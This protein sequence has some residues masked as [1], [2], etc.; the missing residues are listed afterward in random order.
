[1]KTLPILALTLLLS[2]LPGISQVVCKETEAHLV[3]TC[4]GR[5]VLTYHKTASVP[6]EVD[7][8]YARSGFIHPLSTPSGRVL[9]DDYPVPHH[10]HQHGVFFAWKSAS[11][12]G[13][14]LNFWEPGRDTVRHEKVIDILNED[15]VAG[16][17]VALLHASGAEPVIRE[18]W[19]VKVSGE[20]GWIDFTSEQRCV[21]G[22]PL[23]IERFHYGGMAVR[24][25]RQW[26]KDAHTESG[27]G[28]TKDEFVEASTLLT[29]QGFT[30]ANGN[31]SRPK[32]VCMSGP[33]NGAAVFLTMIP[34]PS[35]FRYPQHVRLHPEMPYFCFIPTVEQ[36]FR[37]QPDELWVSRY[38][39]V[40]GDGEPEMAALNAIQRDFAE[41]K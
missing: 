34:H 29:D 38:R 17:R 2:L 4:D 22:S 15:A 41:V 25:S 18:I 39:I 10:A 33:V 36:P 16:F 24:G 11:L 6:D 31:H 37:L 14:K 40:V 1:M 27:K 9:T 7:P 35:N 3:V 20:N 26:F 21:A 19:T 23:T 32:W 12:R 30:Q 13:K 5:H 28:A 8:K